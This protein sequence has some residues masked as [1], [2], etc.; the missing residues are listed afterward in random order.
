MLRTC[1]CYFFR[2]FN[3]RT[4]ILAA[5]IGNCQ[6][7]RSDGKIAVQHCIFDIGVSVDLRS[8]ADFL[9]HCRRHLLQIGQGRRQLHRRRC[10]SEIVNIARQLRRSAQMKLILI[11]DNVG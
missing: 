6:R 7:R 10:A 5:T 8:A 1:R 9:R 11:L 4:E 3:A 2:K